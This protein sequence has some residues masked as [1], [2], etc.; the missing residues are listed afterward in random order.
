MGKRYSYINYK[1]EVLLLADPGLNKNPLNLQ[2]VAY[3]I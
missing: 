1:K 3:F 2:N